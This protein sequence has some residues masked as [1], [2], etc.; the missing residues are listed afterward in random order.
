MEAAIPAPAS[1]VVFALRC[2]GVPGFPLGPDGLPAECHRPTSLAPTLA[3]HPERARRL[4]HLDAID[5]LARE[6]LRVGR[7]FGLGWGWNWRGGRGR[8]RGA[9]ESNEP[10]DAEPGLGAR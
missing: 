3:Y 4:S 1:Q 5:P 7:R 8:R 2:P 10:Y 9:R 6:R